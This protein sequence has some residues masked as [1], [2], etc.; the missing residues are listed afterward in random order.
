MPLVTNRAPRA[1]AQISHTVEYRTVTTIE[2]TTKTVF[3][4]K[5]DYAHHL[6][7]SSNGTIRAHTCKKKKKLSRG[8]LVDSAE[9][10]SK[11]DNPN[12][13]NMICDSLTQYM[14]KIIHEEN[15]AYDQKIQQFEKIAAI[16][17]VDQRFIQGL[18]ANGYGNMKS[19]LYNIKETLGSKLHRIVHDRDLP[20]QKKREI[21]RKLTEVLSNFF[22]P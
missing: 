7:S 18:I 16:L 13:L 19:T 9:D 22:V 6:A 14:T 12:Y 15:S 21:F 5:K 4:P 11:Y 17:G 8:E 20:H 2:T 3:Q 10:I 1:P